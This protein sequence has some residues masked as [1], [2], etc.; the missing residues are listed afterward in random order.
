VE[1]GLYVIDDL[2]Q[3][4]DYSFTDNKYSAYI[5]INHKISSKTSMKAGLN[6]DWYQ[7][8]HMDS[9]RLV[10]IDPNDLVEPTLDPWRVRWDSDDGAI[11]LQP[12]VQ[13]KYKASPRLTMTGGLTSLYFGINKESFSPLEPRLGLSYDLGKKQRLNAGIGYHSQMWPTYIYYYSLESVGKDPTEHNLDNIGLTK[14]LHTVLG[15]E[16]AFTSNMRLKAETYFQYLHDIPVKTVSS[17]YALINSGSGF[18]RFFPDELEN[19]GIGRNFGIELT[20]ERFFTQGY[21]FLITGSLFD[22]RYQGSDEIWRNTSFNGHYGVNGL[23][24]KEFAFKNG[25][26]FN[27]G[28]KVTFAGGRRYGDVDNAASLLAQDVVYLENE[29]YNEYQFDPYFRADLK[30]NYK[31]NRPKVTHEFSVDVVNLFDIKNILSLTYAPDHPSD[32]DFV[33][34]YQIGLLPIFYY[35]LDFRL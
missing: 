10:R 15:Y 13:F 8:R 35:K 26:S 21:Y 28:G 5:F 11:M 14:S 9:A 4:L 6:T 23:F 7:M 16:K 24:A 30:L 17:P 22:S 18:S 31:I 29:N 32:S 19:S 1:E 3:I 2:P 12:Y 27:V 33:E 20:V 25:S 34:E